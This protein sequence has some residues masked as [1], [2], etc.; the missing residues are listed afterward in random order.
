MKDLDYVN[1][2]GA[3]PLYMGTLGE[4]NGNKYLIFVNTDK[5]KEVLTKYTEYC[6]KIK[7]LIKTINDKPGDYEEKYMKIKFISDDNIPLN[8]LL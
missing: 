8:K 3:N 6:D 2:L 7:D 5:N 4:S 1:I